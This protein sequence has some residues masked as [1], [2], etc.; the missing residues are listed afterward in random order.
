MI[1]LSKN[2]RSINTSG[3]HVD[4]GDVEALGA[5]FERGHP[6]HGLTH[7]RVNPAEYDDPFAST[8]WRAYQA[9]HAAAKAETADVGEPVA[10][11]HFAENGNIRLWAPERP[12]DLDGNIAQPLYTAD[13]LAAAVA[14][15]RERAS[16][17]YDM[18]LNRPALNAGLESEYAAEAAAKAADVGEPVAFAHFAEN[19]NIRL[20]APERPLDIDGKAAQPLYTADQ[21]AAAVAAER[22]KCAG[23]VNELRMECARRNMPESA[24]MLWHA[25]DAIRAGA[26]E[27]S[28]G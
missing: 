16:V 7:C 6:D 26:K 18:L 3:A 10:W 1:D 11:A 23:I 12:R 22:G 17:L 24:T 28:D 5:H 2:Q 9:G 20:W 15:E 14:K 13:Q 4:G 27:P 25:E 19:G 21:L 8:A